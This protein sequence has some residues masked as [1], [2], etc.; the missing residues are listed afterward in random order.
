MIK[1]PI[2]LI[3]I[4][5][6][7]TSIN[8]VNR[9]HF[10]CFF[11]LMLQIK[12]N[13]TILL[14]VSFYFIYLNYPFSI[15]QIQKNTRCYIFQILKSL[16]GFFVRSRYFFFQ[17]PQCFMQDNARCFSVRVSNVPFSH[18]LESVHPIVF[19]DQSSDLS[20]NLYV[21]EHLV[22]LLIISF[23]CAFVLSL[24]FSI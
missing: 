13:T 24:S 9:A 21:R 8:C 10:F 14:Q 6:A 16:S 2:T 18:P 23:I 17:I 20:S 22:F 3:K 5:S 15:L 1:I 19:L 12:E 7:F 11:I 4:P